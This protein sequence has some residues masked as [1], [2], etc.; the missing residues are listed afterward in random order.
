MFTLLTNFKSV[1]FCLIWLV[2]VQVETIGDAYMVVGG[3]HKIVSTH[4]VRIANQAL[5][6]LFVS[7]NVKSPVTHKPLDV[8]ILLH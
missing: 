1:L 5:G 4:A 2:F 8:N 7:R 6:M 3:L